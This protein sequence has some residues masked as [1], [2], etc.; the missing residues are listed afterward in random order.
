MIT[1]RRNFSE[2]D[3]NNTPTAVQ[4]EFF[5]LEQLVLDLSQEKQ[6]LEQLVHQEKTKANKN[7][8]NSDKPPSS[9]NPYVKRTNSHDK[10]AKGK[11]GAKIGHKGQRQKLMPPTNTVEIR[12][13]Q[14]DCGDHR[15]KNMQSFYT[16]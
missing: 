10:E 3:W 7:S 9:D 16:R 2:S 13:P 1:L 11:P 4:K 5:R 12:P 8:S 15:L 6:R 14:C